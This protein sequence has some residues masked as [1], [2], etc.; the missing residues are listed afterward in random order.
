MSL[1]ITACHT[2]QLRDHCAGGL[3]AMADDQRP[4]FL[5]LTDDALLLS[6][7]NHFL[8]LPGLVRVCV[9]AIKFP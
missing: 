4:L 5:R 9:A 8:A 7:F 3:W 6:F 2:S 1:F